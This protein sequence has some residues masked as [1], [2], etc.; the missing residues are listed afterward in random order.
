M[1]V[2]EWENLKGTR[3]FRRP[4]LDFWG[5][6]IIRAMNPLPL[7]IA[8]DDVL[9]C[10]LSLV[11]GPSCMC[12]LF[13]FWDTRPYFT[14]QCGHFVFPAGRRS[15]RRG[16]F[17]GFAPISSFHSNGFFICAIEFVSIPV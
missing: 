4:A 10:Y 5:R 3:V 6:P 15:R 8:G 12:L 17:P 11:H 9:F 16:R 2:S 7:V 1:T 14:D 13:W